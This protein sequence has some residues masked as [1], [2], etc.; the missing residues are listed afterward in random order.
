MWRKWAKRLLIRCV[1]RHD[2]QVVTLDEQMRQS[3]DTPG[4]TELHELLAEIRESF[5]I[6]QPVLEKL[7]AR[8]IGEP[9]MPKSMADMQEPTII[10]PRHTLLNIINEHMIPRLAVHAGQRLIKFYATIRGVDSTGGEHALPEG[11]LSAARERPRLGT[12]HILPQYAFFQGQELCFVH[13]NRNLAA[14]WATNS[15][16][17]LRTVV[18]DQREPPDPGTGEYWQLQYMPL[19]LIVEPMDAHPLVA[20][21]Q[22]GKDL[23]LGCLAVLPSTES[24]PLAIPMNMRGPA[25]SGTELYVRR[26]GFHVVPVAAA[27]SYFNQ[28]N[29][30]PKPKPVVSDL[31]IPMDGGVSPAA[32]YVCLS[33]AQSLEQVYLL[34][35]LWNTDAEKSWFLRK[36]AG[37]Y[38]Y[39][40]D[41]VAAMKY[42]ATLTEETRTK[43]PDQDLHYTTAA[44]PW[45]C[46]TCGKD[47]RE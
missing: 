14:G 33:R 38:K 23:P 47:L 34:H 4:A 44:N 2:V 26:K 46:A 45:V 35:P 42:L 22:M 21:S 6:P 27:T 43:H 8:A 3:A 30:V 24:S 18:F 11:L 28:G 17:K 31:R 15:S 40:Q 12:E 10:A 41:T 20:E 19:A 7:N 1:G 37:C 32:P 16:C 29:T 39:D 25:G 5:G 9:G 36:A 13:G